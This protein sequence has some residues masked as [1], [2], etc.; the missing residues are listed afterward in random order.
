[1]YIH[2]GNKFLQTMLF[3][4]IVYMVYFHKYLME[5]VVLVV[6]LGVVEEP[7]DLEVMVV[8]EREKIHNILSNNEYHHLYHNFFLHQSNYNHTLDLVDL[9]D[10]ED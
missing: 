2:L 8:L 6:V 1:M 9:E 4:H 3:L 10:L 5:V 7:V